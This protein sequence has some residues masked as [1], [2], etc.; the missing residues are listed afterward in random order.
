M[1]ESCLPETLVFITYSHIFLFPP[2]LLFPSSLGIHMAGV[3]LIF[4]WEEHSATANEG[5]WGMAPARLGLKGPGIGRRGKNREDG[6][7]DAADWEHGKRGYV[8]RRRGM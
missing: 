5:N 2:S 8:S 6:G 4:P 1:T 3:S 7:K